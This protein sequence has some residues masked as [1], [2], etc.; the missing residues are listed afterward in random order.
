MLLPRREK[1]V[2]SVKRI[3][4]GKNTI[5]EKWDNI[6]KS[7]KSLKNFDSLARYVRT[8]SEFHEF[9]LLE[10]NRHLC[11]YKRDALAHLLVSDGCPVHREEAFPVYTKGD[12]NFFYF[13]C[14]GLFMAMRTI[15]LK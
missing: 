15:M 9:S 3:I 14:L 4:A 13:H 1:F 8:L 5:E 6:L 11:H 10:G 7:M 12:G 2:K